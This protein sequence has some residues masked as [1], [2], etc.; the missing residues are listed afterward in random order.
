MLRCA[1][2]PLTCNASAADNSTPKWLMRHGSCLLM[3]VALF[4]DLPYLLPPV[5]VGPFGDAPPPDRD[6]DRDRAIPSSPHTTPISTGRAA[7]H[8]RQ[9]ATTFAVSPRLL[10]SA[11]SFG[12]SE[13]QAS[14]SEDRLPMASPRLRGAD[15]LADTPTE[16]SAATDHGHPLDLV[17]HRARLLRHDCRR[18]VAASVQKCHLAYHFLS[19]RQRLGQ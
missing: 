18:A 5:P 7:N 17:W 2:C 6:R 12:Q 1:S 4:A 3:H 11:A 14:A 9:R 16:P 13:L 8:S 19:R 15:G 10:S